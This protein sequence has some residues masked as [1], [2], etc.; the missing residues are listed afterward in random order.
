MFKHQITIDD[1]TTYELNTVPAVEIKENILI[2]GTFQKGRTN[3]LMQFLPGEYQKFIEELGA[4]NYYKYGIGPN[5]ALDALD[6]NLNMGVLAI[7]LR[8]AD[9]TYAN[10]MLIAKYK[11]L[12]DVQKTNESGDPLF[13]TPGGVETIVA[14][15]NTPIVRDV[16]EIKFSTMSST[17]VTSKLKMITELEVPYSDTVD[18]SGYKTMPLFAFYYV[19]SGDFGDNLNLRMVDRES[20]YNGE[21][22]YDVELFNGITQSYVNG[23]SLFPDAE[24]F[25]G[26][27]IFIENIMKTNPH[28]NVISSPRLDE[29]L[30]IVSQYSDNPKLLNLFDIEDA[31]AI[32]TATGSLDV[33][34]PL[35]IRLANGTDGN[36][37]NLPTVYKDF[38]DSK[39]VPDLD[40]IIRYRIDLIPD[41]EYGDDVK[42]AILN[43]LKR[44]SNTT[45]T[46]MLLGDATFESAIAERETTYRI[47]DDS[48]TLFIAAC[49]KPAIHD[50]YTKRTLRLPA[51][52]YSTKAYIDAYKRNQNSFLAFAGASARWTGF[53]PDSLMCPSNT[54]AM[55][56]L[57][58]DS[59]I[60]V[61][62]M[63]SEPGAYIASQSTNTVKLSDRTEFNNMRV[64]AHI[65][66][67]IANLVH[68]NSYKFNDMEDIAKFE[69]KIQL[70][71]YPEF[72]PY[73]SGLKAVVYKK[74][75]TGE[76][77]NT[78]LINIKVNFKDLAKA[79]E[80]T[81]T[82]TDSEIK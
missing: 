10:A 50:R 77:K 33:T 28:I 66:Y 71:I 22:M 46:I 38:F 53:D 69:E 70:D 39:I 48:N 7:N 29:F 34:A 37:S 13:L 2:A 43:L 54:V 41:L 11:V 8:P 25:G 79:T 36:L 47:N 55:D 18:A 15:G 64:M 65:I 31:Y 74:G 21:I 63:D 3:Q 61:V 1:Q 57:F 82:I 5:I 27:T 80:T 24:I 35:A 52:Y 19:G 60:N 51:I 42:T 81:I 4:P 17:L 12:P 32:K 76:D 20:P 62:K 68:K 23:V 45:Q 59:R 30:A 14:T 58:D 26:E 73:V 6:N 56:K 49:Q 40:S 67:K 16:L 9:A 72:K 44:R 78:N 75:L